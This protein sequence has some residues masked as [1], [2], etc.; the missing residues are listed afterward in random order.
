MLMQCPTLKTRIVSARTVAIVCLAFAFQTYYINAFAQ[1]TAASTP[2]MLVTWFG[3]GAI[4]LPHGQDWKAEMLTVYDNVTRPVAQ[5][6]KGDAGLTVSFSIFENQS[7]KPSAE[8]CR[9]DA[10]S[11]ILKHDA[12]LISKRVDGEVKTTTGETLATTSYLLDMGLAGGHYSHNL[13]GF[14][15]NAKAC[16]EIHI[17]SVSGTPTEDRMKFV[18]AGFHPD[19]T[20]QPNALDYFRLASVLFK[21]SPSLAAPYYKASLDAMPSDTT[22]ITPRRVTTDQLVMSLGMSGDLKNSR[23]VAEKAIATDPDYP[24]NYYNLACAD[25]EQGDATAAKL[26]LQQ[27]FDRQANVLKGESMPDPT[28]DDSILKL[29]KN[30]AFWAFVLTLPKK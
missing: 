11:P 9:E 25:A 4:A 2:L 24:L 5:F 23:A 15:G 7:G 12:K 3:P 30:E 20:Y 29:K 17:S 26:H 19:L 22:S 1:Q 10:I 21:D 16:A 28:K 8:G 13:F 14:T 6:S 18:L 27:A